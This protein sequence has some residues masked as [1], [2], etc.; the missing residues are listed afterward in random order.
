MEF[1]KIK[2]C[3][4]NFNSLTKIY[5]N[6]K[7]IAFSVFFMLCSP[8]CPF[9]NTIFKIVSAEDTI[10]GSIIFLNV[11]LVEPFSTSSY[12]TAK[13]KGKVTLSIQI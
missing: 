13:D 3:N 5:L 11:S 10:R 1:K 2:A 12:F 9:H 6:D 4:D 7:V 8:T